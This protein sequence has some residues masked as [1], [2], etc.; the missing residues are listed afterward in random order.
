MKERRRASLDAAALLDYALRVLA[1]RAHSSG[2]LREM[3]RRQQR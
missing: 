3:L 2:E 1:G